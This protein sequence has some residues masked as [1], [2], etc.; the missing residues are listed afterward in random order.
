[1]DKNLQQL[2]HVLGIT[3]V[4][5]TIG[6][7]CYP[8][9][10]AEEQQPREPA[11]DTV[12]AMPM[13]II[14]VTGVQKRVQPIKDVPIAMTVVSR[15][16]L[17]NS[18]AVTLSDMQQLAPN[19]S[20]AQSEVRIRGIGG[21]GN[22][23]GFDTRVG[24]Y[25][26]GIYMGQ[27]QALDQTL[28]DV[29]QVEV[30]RG[31][32]GHLF[33][34]NTVAGAVNITTRAPAETFESSF[35]AGAGNY[36][37]REAH[38]SVSGSIADKLLGKLSLGYETRDGF[39]T[40]LFN[41][42]T[43]DGLKRASMRGQLAIQASDRLEINLSAD[44]ADIKLSAIGGETMTGM[45]GTPMAGGPYASHTVNVNTTPYSNSTLSGIGLTANYDM[46]GGNTLTA[47][48]A[49]R[50]TRQDL[51]Q[52]LDL[53]PLDI[54]R[55]K[56]SDSFK[57]FSQE[58]RIASPAKDR[59]RYVAG[60]Y[61]VHESADTY[62]IATAGNDAT[63]VFGVPVGTAIPVSGAVKTNSYALFGALDYDLAS[64]LTLNLGARYTHEKKTLLYNLA[65]ADILGFGNAVNYTDARSDAMLTPTAGVSYA[66]DKSLNIYGKYSTGFKSGGWN[67][68][69]LSTTQIANKF[70]FNKESVES[71]ELG[72]KG[73][74]F[75]HRMHYDFSV[76]QSN[77]KD[78]QVIQLVNTGV[79]TE[80]Q[81]RNAAKVESTGAEASFKTMA[82]QNLDIGGS[83]GIVRAV[84]KSF[85]GGLT[86]GG[87]ATGK[88]LPDAPD[89]TTALTMNYSMP[90][91]SMRGRLEFYGE[92]SYRTK[93]FNGADNIEATDGISSRSVVNARV[94]FASN[95]PPLEL[96][97]WARN[98]FNNSYTTVN[99]QSFFGN[100]YVIRGDP[101]S[102]GVEGKYSF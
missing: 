84:F 44:Y 60:M 64:R 79:A 102:F 20:I 21:G 96:S 91:P 62:R 61:L 88:R 56:Y 7:A 37:M 48:T 32:Q 43:L 51:Q 57:Q 50:D 80:L 39:T 59:L 1:M 40:N 78:Y 89:M 77:F 67:L 68:D 72:L 27:A 25:V 100:Q 38:G 86:G 31:P 55:I 74:A 66:V 34:R 15:E 54:L 6:G 11:A 94:S 30:L 5:W 35:S 26:D 46:T 75:D 90:A 16:T 8:A 24:V 23:I 92:Y 97:L 101:I 47:I 14:V 87:D 28:L 69:F 18:R 10:A 93:S 22:N 33:G 19:F 99:G 29:K 36:N 98:L 3:F 58:I 13:E 53:T 17:E 82:T 41:N 70:D 73:S 52:D 85:P 45:F 49:Y 4:A 63:G 9:A 65:G 95:T 83:I 12:P 76:F 42:Q 2:R 81:L 71:Y